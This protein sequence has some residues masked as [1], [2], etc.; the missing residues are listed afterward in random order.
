MEEKRYPHLFSPIKINKTILKNRIISAPIGNYT[1]RSNDGYGMMIIGSVGSVVGP[2]SRFSPSPAAL[3]NGP[4]GIYKYRTELA[5][6]KE[7]GARASVEL[8]WVGSKAWAP[9]GEY[10]FGPQEGINIHGNPIKAM[11]REDMEFVCKQ[12]AL[13]A[14][15]Y[16]QLGAD[17]LL[18]HFGHGWGAAEW[19][20]PS[21]NHRTDEFGGSIE[22]RSR[23]PRM[24]LQAVRDA[25]GKDFPI[26][27]RISAEDGL[28]GGFNVDDLCYFVH[29]VEDLIDMVNLS[30]GIFFNWISTVATAYDPHMVNVRFAEELKK[31]VR[32]PVAVVGSIM[33]PEEA[34]EI[35]ASG[36]A[37]L[38]TIGRAGI[39]DPQWVT[40]A[41]QG[42][43]EDIVP[44]I[45]CMECHEPTCSVSPR[46]LRPERYGMIEIPKT[47]HPKHVVIV[48]GGP[49]GLNAAI[50]SARRG[51]SVTLIEKGSKLGGQITC[52]DYEESKIDLKRYKDYLLHQIEKQKEINIILN[53][54]AT[55]E[56]VRSLKPDS[57]ILAMGAKPVTPAIKGVDSAHV[58]QAVDLYSHLDDAAQDTVI[59]G[60]G[61]VGCEL[62]L[63]LTRKGKHVT[64]VEI[65]K[66]LGG[67]AI[68]DFRKGNSRVNMSSNGGSESLVESLLEKVHAN[69]KITYY[70]NATATEICNGFVRVKQDDHEF[71][72]QAGT[73][74]LAV[75]F[76]ADT[77]EAF[78][79][80]NIVDDTNMIGDLDRVS[81]IHN[82]VQGAFTL[83]SSI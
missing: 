52:S 69:E 14:K 38:V 39:A 44:C 36:K 16:K 55:P 29:H 33:T 2:R 78:S 68:Y 58:F 71:I 1:E 81:N 48:G 15:M 74:V 42:R 20:F 31:H 6:V 47:D 67:P 8:M 56:L 41:Q 66:E 22:N 17:V 64:I 72:I 79:F 9:A 60:G 62:A 77:D 49:A 10:V 32:I 73:V 30:H 34:E 75:G 21:M 26:D 4:Q 13:S 57:L 40:K 80:Y 7:H 12:Y 50:Y 23:F 24:I 63:D 82:A 53:T 43:S 76:R 35:I 46:C 28:E 18:V 3:D 37:D 25:V 11:T 45:R 65:A 83:A 59:I 51:N 27:L 54:S 19:L 70:T 61:V 5:Q